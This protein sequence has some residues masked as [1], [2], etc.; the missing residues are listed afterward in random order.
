MK[1]QVIEIIHKVNIIEAKSEGEAV[2]KF[3]EKYTEAEVSNEEVE[4][5]PYE[6]AE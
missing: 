3:Y 4:V 5:H 6:A 1:Y 2:K